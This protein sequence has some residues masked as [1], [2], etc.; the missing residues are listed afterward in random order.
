MMPL[1]N[2]IGILMLRVA[3]ERTG[4]GENELTNTDGTPS[5]WIEGGKEYCNPQY[6]KTLPS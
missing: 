5:Y 3:V 4:T 1:L 2:A 6:N